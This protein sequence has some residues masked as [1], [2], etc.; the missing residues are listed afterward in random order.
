MGTGGLLILASVPL[1][2]AYLSHANKAI[3]MYKSG[4]RYL[5]HYRYDLQLNLAINSVRFKLLLCSC[6]RHQLILCLQNLHWKLR[7][8]HLLHHGS[9]RVQHCWL[10]P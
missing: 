10:L 9:V 6:I 8:L 1:H 3:K 5:G 4:Q 2:V 7:L